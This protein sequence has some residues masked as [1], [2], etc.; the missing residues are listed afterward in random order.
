MQTPSVDRETLGP[1]FV[2]Y[3]TRAM[4]IFHFVHV[5]NVTLLKLRRNMLIFRFF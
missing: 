3:C 5:K 1:A 2:L 4:F